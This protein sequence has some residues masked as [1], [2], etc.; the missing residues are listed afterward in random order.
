MKSKLWQINFRTALL[1]L[2]DSLVRDFDSLRHLVFCVLCLIYRD[3]QQLAG[4]CPDQLLNPVRQDYSHQ[5]CR[6][7]WL[8][9]TAAFNSNNICHTPWN[10]CSE[11]VSRWLATFAI[12]VCQLNGAYSNSQIFT[13]GF[14]CYCLWWYID[15]P[16]SCVLS[17]VTSSKHFDSFY[18]E[19]SIDGDVWF[20][21]LGF[22]LQPVS[23]AWM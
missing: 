9:D 6:Y 2:C 23:T 20:F 16:L 8:Y 1:F 5:C 15:E 4:S 3:K 12:T 21:S 17:E 22:A 19:Q 10:Y 13:E 7:N 14:F 18:Q 11:T